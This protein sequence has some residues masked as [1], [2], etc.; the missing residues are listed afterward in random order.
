MLPAR[1][2]IVAYVHMYPP[3]HLA[4]AEVMLHSMLRWLVARGWTCRVVCIGGRGYRYGIGPDYMLDGVS[5]SEDEVKQL[6]GADVILTHLDRTPC[7][8]SIAEY[9][10]VPLVH[11]LHN[12]RTLAVN[13]VTKADLVVYNTHWLKAAVRWPCPG[14][15]VHPPIIREDYATTPGDCV[16]LVNLQQGKGVRLFY[17]LAE[18]MP[19]TRFLGVTGAY[20]RQEIASRDNVEIVGPVQDMREVYSRTRVLLM[21]STYE[22]YGRV[23]VEAA[24]SGIPT[25][26]NSTPGTREALGNGGIF[27]R[28]LDAASWQTAIEGVQADYDTASVLALAIADRLDMDGEMAAF[29]TAIEGLI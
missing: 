9:L 29:E 6:T 13:H 27:P 14:V 2:V 21:P 1:G 23:G 16:T 25:I 11:L 8:E 12:H 4:G 22:S 24:C 26:A 17:E 10:R 28:G 3:M 19:D 5:V 20:G 7:A 18:R 15:V